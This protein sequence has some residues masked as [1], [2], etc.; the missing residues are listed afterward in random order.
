MLAPDQCGLRNR[1][2][3]ARYSAVDV[4]DVLNIDISDVDVGYIH[5]CY[6]HVPDIGRAGPIS[7][8]INFA[9]AKREPRNHTAAAIRERPAAS[10]HERHERRRIHGPGHVRSGYPCPGSPDVS[11]A[12]VVEWRKPPRRI[13]N[14]GPSPWVHPGPVTVP[15]GG[16][17]CRN[18]GRDPD[19]SIAWNHPPGAVP[20]QVLVPGHIRRNVAVASHVSRALCLAPVSG[21]APIVPA[22]NGPGRL[23]VVA[24]QVSARYDG[25]LVRID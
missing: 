5:V 16:P 15:V 2:N 20:I 14:P 10:A 25:G 19:R 9:W 6:I 8:N 24:D 11:P 12:S 17:T 7:R 3:R 22:V 1:R 4:V 18:R 23:D 21:N 13:V